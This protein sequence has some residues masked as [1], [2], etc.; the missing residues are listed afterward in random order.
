[1]PLEFLCPGCQ[2]QYRVPDAFAG[3]GV[4]CKRCGV[5]IAIACLPAPAGAGGAAPVETPVLPGGGTPDL[6]SLLDE[7]LA[8]PSKPASWDSLSDAMAGYEASAA[9]TYAPKPRKRTWFGRKRSRGKREKKGGMSWLMIAGLMFIVMPWLT[10]RPPGQPL[11]SGPYTAG[12]LIG[13]SVLGLI[14]MCL[15]GLSGRR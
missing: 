13:S 2:Q 8:A 11:I 3:K 1:M 12:F 10:P 6:G 4:K 5:L 9:E 14:L 7:A 15:G